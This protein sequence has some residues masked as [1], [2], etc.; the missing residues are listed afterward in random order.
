ML[1]SHGTSNG[2]STWLIGDH[3]G[4]VELYVSIYAPNSGKNLEF[5][6]YFFCKLHSLTD[7]YNVD[8][9]FISGDFNIVLSGGSK[10]GRTTSKYEAKLLLFIED[11]LTN[12]GLANLAGDNIGLHMWGR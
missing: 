7:Q 11:N 8:K 3:N 10:A 5:Y 9:I 12:L 2:R 1:Y 6:R 4:V